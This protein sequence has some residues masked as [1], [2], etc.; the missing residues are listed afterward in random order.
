MTAGTYRHPEPSRIEFLA[1]GTECLRCAA[2]GAETSDSGQAQRPW[3]KGK[4][5]GF[6]KPQFE[7]AEEPRIEGDPSGL[8]AETA[9]SHRC[10]HLTSTGHQKACHVRAQCPQLRKGSHQAAMLWIIFDSL[11]AGPK[12]GFTATSHGSMPVLR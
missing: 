2:A 11:S 6:S 4:H 10:R 7:W 9:V 3:Q 8:W 1:N 5:G 12:K